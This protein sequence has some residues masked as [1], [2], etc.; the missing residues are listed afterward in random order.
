[1]SRMRPLAAD[2]IAAYTARMGGGGRRRQPVPASSPPFRGKGG[3]GSPGAG[4]RAGEPPGG[5]A[6]SGEP[7][8]TS[9]RESAVENELGDGAAS[10]FGC[11]RRVHVTP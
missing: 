8:S 4:E 5:D 9:H 6:G 3:S 11:P 10:G 2:T 7:L 1:V